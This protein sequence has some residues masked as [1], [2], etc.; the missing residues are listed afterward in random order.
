MS[1]EGSLDLFRLP[2]ILQ[3]IGQQAKTGILTVQGEQD[4][5]AVSFLH[6]RIVAADSLAHTVEEGLGQVLVGRG[7]LRG[8]DFARV[9]SESQSSG[10]RLVDVLVERKLVQREQVLEGL[11]EQMR[12]QLV[13]LL[14]WERGDF[15]FYTGDEVSYEDGFMP[16]SVEDLLLGSLEEVAAPPPRPAPVTPPPSAPAE[17]PWDGFRP[18]PT[19]RAVPELGT[20]ASSRPARIP[21]PA[22]SPVTPGPSRSAPLRV[23]QPG[24]PAEKE[25]AFG[26]AAAGRSS[27]EL[28]A[29]LPKQF[30]KMELKES[31]PTVRKGEIAAAFGLAALLVVGVLVFLVRRPGDVV[32]GFPW[33]AADRAAIQREQRLA[34]SIKIDRAAKTFYL[35]EGRFPDSLGQLVDGGLLS[36]GDLEDPEGRPLQY[37]SREESYSVSPVSGG[38]AIQEMETSQGIS[39]NF[40]LD[41]Q[42][43]VPARNTTA[44]IVLLD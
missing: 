9:A 8:Q 14:R 31:R 10:A 3:M 6:G 40:L 37:T 12:R 5:V 17:A 30:R 15:K 27:A 32:L 21:R 44:P 26:P 28:E 29:P 13:Q 16:I 23:V 33:E 2:E 19:L 42:L 22:A 36:A 24:A 39:G 1:V 4:I 20:E 35:L 25:Q 34:Q 41:P 7:L 38:K 43:L 11:R 18:P